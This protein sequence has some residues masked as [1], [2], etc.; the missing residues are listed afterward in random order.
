ILQYF[1]RR[2]P[3]QRDP[4][5]RASSRGAPVIHRVEPK[6]QFSALGDRKQFRI[7]QPQFARAR[8]VRAR[9]IKLVFATLPR[10]AIDDSAVGREPGIAD[11]AGAKRDLLVLGLR[12]AGAGLTSPP[13]KTVHRACD[14]QTG[15]QCEQKPATRLD[16]SNAS[17]S[18]RWSGRAP[19]KPGKMFEIKRN[20]ACGMKA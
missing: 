3:T 5:R 11:G 10:R 7:L 18:R 17:T 12:R 15:C 4:P 8:I 16:F 2:S 14:N 19:G 13:T 1:S 20:I 6:R 9:H